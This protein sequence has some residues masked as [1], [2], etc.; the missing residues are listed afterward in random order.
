MSVL[1]WTAIVIVA[2][3]GAGLGVEGLLELRDR[4]RYPP[5]GELVDIGGG[6]KLHIYCQGD[7]PGPTVVIEQGLGS[8]SIVWHP[9]QAAIARFGRVC[10]YDRAGFL[11]SDPG[12]P[13]RSLDDMAA[14][15]HTLLKRSAMPAPYLLVAHSMG[16][17][18]ARRFAHMYPDLAAGLV[19]VDSPDEAVVFR[20]SIRPFYAQGLRMQQIMK[21][22]AR[23]GWL[24]LLGRH[25][26]ILMLPDDPVGYALCVRPQHAQA[27]ADEMRAMLNESVLTRQPERP[28]SLED[29]PLVILGHGIPFPPVAAAMEEGWSDGLQRLRS[30]SSASE[31]VIA[32][33]SGHLVHV[34]E[35]E[36]VVESVRRVHAAIRDRTRPTLSLT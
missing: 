12:K 13:G 16:G 23:L 35:P 26:P 6:R 24:R 29:R 36:L 28:G 8:P 34:D 9:V 3:L 1:L 20:D 25:V 5:P 30:L 19:L 31:L 32:Q 27:C 14:D 15:L 17:L 22:F 18:I 10:T 2:L 4:R 33:K 11:W 7:A 21:V